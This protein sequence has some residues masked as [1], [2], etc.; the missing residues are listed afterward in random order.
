MAEKIKKENNKAQLDFINRIK[1]M[2]PPNLTLVDELAELLGMSNDSAY[3]RIRGETAL[4][5]EEITLICSKHKISFDSFSNNAQTGSVTFNYRPLENNELNFE[6]YLGNILNDLKKFQAFENKQI[7]FA[8]EDIPIFHYF[9]YPEL[10][11]FKMFYWNKSIL[12]VPSLEGKKF[13][14]AYVSKKNIEMARSIL[15]EY[16]SIPSVEIWTED[17]VNS[18]IKQIELYW[19]SG[20]FKSKEDAIMIF[21]E[22]EK[23]LNKIKRQAELSSKFI[24]EEKWA[25]N[26]NNYTLYSS[27]IMIGNN[28]ILVT[29]GNIKATYLSHHTFN[30]MITTNNGFCAETESWLKNLIRKSVQIS[31]VSEKQRYQFFRK[32]EDAMQ[33][34]KAKIV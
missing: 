34:L 8:A 6:S 14:A 7:I 4:S 15:E 26:E 32:I 1:D 33:R 13:E 16:I 10:T 21:E 5:L 31:G 12:G 22:L 25:Q 2:I 19:E 3:R 20:L 28:S 24:D 18:T 23:M 30:T 27:E 11:A 29:M 9:S 17:T